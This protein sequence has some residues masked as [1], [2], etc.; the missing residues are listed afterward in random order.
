MGKLVLVCHGH[1][2]L[3]VPG[4]DD[5]LRK[6]VLVSRKQ[7]SE[8]VNSSSFLPKRQDW[9]GRIE[10][11]AGKCRPDVSQKSFTYF[12]NTPQKSPCLGRG[13]QRQGRDESY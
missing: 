5:R 9:T 7:F 8:N 1:T 11:V 6:R 3:N 12:S 13:R 10:R 2:C 4:R